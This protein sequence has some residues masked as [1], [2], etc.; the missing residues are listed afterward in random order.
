MI[1]CHPTH[2]D[3]FTHFLRSEYPTDSQFPICS[4][5]CFIPSIRTGPASLRDF[6]SFMYFVLFPPHLL[7]HPLFRPLSLP[8]QMPFI[9][10]HHGGG[11]GVVPSLLRSFSAPSPTDGAAA[12]SDYGPLAE[13]LASGPTPN[14]IIGTGSILSLVWHATFG[15][16]Y[17]SSYHFLPSH[18]VRPCPTPTPRGAPVFP[19][20]DFYGVLGLPLSRGH[21]PPVSNPHPPGGGPRFF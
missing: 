19:N 21:P 18:G 10:P 4:G 15:L 5:S 3:A 8:P 17:F 1:P 7:I 20:H 14:F 2:G 16:I 6:I 9:P 13:L 12:P 11:I